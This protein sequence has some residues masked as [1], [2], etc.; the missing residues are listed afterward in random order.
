VNNLSSS[1]VNYYWDFGDGYTTTQEHPGGHTYTSPGTYR[2]MLAVNNDTS[3]ITDDTTYMT[4]TVLEVNPPDIQVDDTVLCTLE[5]A[6]DISVKVNNPSPNNR[7][8]WESTDPSAILS[9]ATFPTVQVDPSLSG[10]YYITVWDTIPGICGFSTTDTLHIDLAPRSLV[11]YNNDTTVCEGD[12]VSI[13]ASGTEGYTYSWFPTVGV[14]EPTTLNPNITIDHQEV[15]IYTLTASYPSCP[16]T[17]ASIRIDMHWLPHLS[18]TGDKEVCQGKEVAL[19]STVSP[20]RKDYTY[21]WS[22][23][24]GLSHTDGPNT[25]FISDTTI[26][27]YLEVETPIGCKAKDSITVWVHPGNF[28]EAISDTGY[29]PPGEVQL[30]A[31]GGINY[32]W[33][34]N[35]G[36]S[37]FT[38]SDPVAKPETP[39]NYTVYVTNQFDC[40][41]TIEVFVDVYP[42]AVITMPDSITIYSGEQYHLEVSTNGHYFSWFPPSGISDIHVADPYFNPEVRTRYFVTVRTEHGCEVVDS[43]DVL[44]E[45]VVLDMP[46]AF[47][48]GSPVNGEFKIVKRGIARLNNFVIYNRWGSKVFE[49]KDIDHGWDGNTD[50]KPQPMGVYVYIIEGITE[51]GNHFSKQGNV[52][53]VR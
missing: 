40:T 9:P 41:D 46:N 37:D 21:Q 48:P 52:T 33:T 27:Y 31:S 43:I 5:E 45:N 32:V 47:T 18:I 14:D 44:V 3:C 15:T 4:I 12:V 28:A 49:T 2:I 13:I 23:V 25:L 11:I 53:L 16:D 50:G 8:L 10:T 19:S 7:Y 26:T 36:L 30:W 6:I 39:T 51:D 17:S 35:Y 42:K 34:P 38:V 1:G 29:C 24:T 22:P 20:Y